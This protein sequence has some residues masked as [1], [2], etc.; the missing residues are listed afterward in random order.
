MKNIVRFFPVALLLI[1]SIVLLTLSCTKVHDNNNGGGNDTTIVPPPPP[2]PPPPPVQKWFKLA[3]SI[4]DGQVMK[5]LHGGRT[6][7][8]YT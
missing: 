5:Y 3:D 2:P 8:N 6:T 7:V 1:F 4:S